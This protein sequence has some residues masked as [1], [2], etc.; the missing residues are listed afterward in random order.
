MNFHNTAEPIKNFEEISAVVEN[1]EILSKNR[2]QKN[3]KNR[4]KISSSNTLGK[5]Q[6]LLKNSGKISE[7]DR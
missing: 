1:H 7:T 3:F 6:K 4:R 2:Y 5:F